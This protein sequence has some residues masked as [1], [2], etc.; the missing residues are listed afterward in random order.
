MTID[1]ASEQTN[2]LKGVLLFLAII[3]MNRLQF[4]LVFENFKKFKYWT[5]SSEIHAPL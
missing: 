2:D 4:I 1:D 5:E 3:K